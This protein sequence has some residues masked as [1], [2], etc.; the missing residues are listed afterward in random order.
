MSVRPRIGDLIKIPLT[1]GINAYAQYVFWDRNYGP[2][3]QVFNFSNQENDQTEEILT[4]GALFPPIITGLFSAIRSGMW[5]VIGNNPIKDFSYPN[6]LSS[7]YDEK[8]GKV[9]QW[10]MWNGDK[11]TKLG[12][13]LPRKYKK[14]E[15]LIV[16]DPKNVEKRIEDG[17]EEPFPYK[18][19]KELNMFNPKKGET[20][21]DEG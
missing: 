15:Y 18:D 4:A 5:E 7:E 17:G 2:L 16:W 6:F 9:K 11:W 3:I 10:F 14:L 12:Q 21:V 19:L 8:T 1:S 13:T 20:N